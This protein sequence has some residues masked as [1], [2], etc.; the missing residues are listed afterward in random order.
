MA[1]VRSGDA[2]DGFVDSSVVCRPKDRRNEEWASSSP[3]SAFRRSWAPGRA[4]VQA[5]PKS[6]QYS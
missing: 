6:K 3:S 2:F 1:G 5:E 4:E